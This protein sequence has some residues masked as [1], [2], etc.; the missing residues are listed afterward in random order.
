[1]HTPFLHV[2]IIH[3]PLVQ[4][5]DVEEC[6]EL[7]NAFRSSGCTAD[8]IDC[9]KLLDPSE[10]EFNFPRLTAEFGYSVPDVDALFVLVVQIPFLHVL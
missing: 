9:E 4:E 6:E 8:D 10:A 5:C 1:M 3:F 7:D 2:V